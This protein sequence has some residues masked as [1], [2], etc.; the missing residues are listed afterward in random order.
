[1]RYADDFLLTFERR[2]DAERLMAVLRQRLARFGLQLHDGKTRLIEFGCFAAERRRER[3]QPRPATFDFLGFTHY[4]GK[5][6]EDR[7]IVRRKTQGRRMIRKLKDLRRQMRWRKHWRLRDQQHWLAAVLRGHYA[8][9]GITGNSRALDRFRR[10]AIKA[11]RWAL[12]RRGQRPK[13]PWDRFKVL[14]EVFPLPTPRIVHQW[15]GA[16]A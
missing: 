6:R 16:A 14:L 10:E 12:R 2:G 3:G 1:M 13:L 15:R 4:C 7:F 5:T 8:Y 9:Y 11:W